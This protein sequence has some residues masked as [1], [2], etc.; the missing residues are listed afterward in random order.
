[1]EYYL[2]P[3]TT[4]ITCNTDVLVCVH[5]G[6]N[7]TANLLFLEKIMLA[8]GKVPQQY[9]VET[10]DSDLDYRLHQSTLDQR[11]TILLCGIAPSLLGLQIKKQLYHPISLGDMLLIQAPTLTSL[12]GDPSAKKYLWQALKSI[13]D[14]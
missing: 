6:D 7:E 3:Q 2:L 5:K 9:H 4:D 14:G 13:M 12:Q 11:M 10:L 1:M 8:Y